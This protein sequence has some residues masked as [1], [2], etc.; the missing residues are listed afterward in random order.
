MKGRHR[1]LHHQK[2]Q[3]S[4]TLVGQ[5]GP[6][7]AS[8]M[9][10]WNTGNYTQQHRIIHLKKELIFNIL[11]KWKFVLQQAYKSWV[12]KK[13]N[14]FS[15]K[16]VTKCCQLSDNIVIRKYRCLNSL[17]LQ[18]P[19]I[20]CTEIYNTLHCTNSIGTHLQT[21]FFQ[22]KVLLHMYVLYLCFYAFYASV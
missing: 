20:T 6:E 16:T 18:T 19:S 13:A 15:T 12:R 21:W 9:F 2:H 11:C 1:L 7:D 22:N 4:T 17:T 5:F 10:L 8:T 3:R 14:N